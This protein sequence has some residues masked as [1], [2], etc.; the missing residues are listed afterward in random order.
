V[1]YLFGWAVTCCCGLPLVL[2]L[3]ALG[4][5]LACHISGVDVPGF[6]KSVGLGVF[7]VLVLVTVQVLGAVYLGV[8][9]FTATE[10]DELL[11]ARLALIGLCSAFFALLYVPVLEIRFGQG[12]RVVL[13]Q[14]TYVGLFVIGWLLYSLAR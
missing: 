1:R 11:L 14:L 6:F 3:Y 12:V 7:T 13:V 9:P 5:R 4:L 8:G 10:A 2:A